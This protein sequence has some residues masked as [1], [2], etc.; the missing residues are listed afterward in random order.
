MGYRTYYSHRHTGS[1]SAPITPATSAHHMTQLLLARHGQGKKHLPPALCPC[2]Q[3]HVEPFSQLT[4]P[5]RG[6][7]SQPPDLGMTMVWPS[8]AI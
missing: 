7:S 6:G 2:S 3:P 1:M 4:L 5:G 8:L